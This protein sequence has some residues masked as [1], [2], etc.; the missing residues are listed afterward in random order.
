MEKE[1]K[2]PEDSTQVP[3]PIDV[4]RAWWFSIR[5]I[6]MRPL[7]KGVGECL[8][9][10]PDVF[11]VIGV[12]VTPD[13]KLTMVTDPLGRH[14]S[15]RDF[16]CDDMSPRVPPA[17]EW[18][19]NVLDERFGSIGR[20]PDPIAFTHDGE[21]RGT[22]LTDT[23]G[24]YH[25]GDLHEVSLNNAQ[26]HQQLILVPSEQAGMAARGVLVYTLNVPLPM[27]VVRAIWWMLRIHQG[28][29][30]M[31]RPPGLYNGMDLDSIVRWARWA[32]KLWITDAEY[33]DGPASDGECP[34]ASSQYR[35]E[36]H[37][38]MVHAVYAGTYAQGI[39]MR[40]A[41][42]GKIRAMLMRPLLGYHRKCVTDY[43]IFALMIQKASTDLEGD[44]RE[45]RIQSLFKLMM[46]GAPLIASDNHDPSIVS[47]W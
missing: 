35:E 5:G 26:V 41:P 30:A 9:L 44:K 39:N 36:W 47:S 15:V 4:I 18:F 7:V 1:I 27:Y 22:V 34:Q 2:V 25:D 12:T 21:G 16:L 46:Y 8:E 10:S 11:A 3:N 40:G 19:C 31:G 28:I 13:G 29:E 23:V 38:Y 32:C 6:H 45:E 20:V 17:V 14:A 43:R 42:N 37:R 24:V 33:Y